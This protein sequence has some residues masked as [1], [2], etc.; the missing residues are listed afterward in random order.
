MI[1]DNRIEEKFAA[2]TLYSNRIREL[3]P[4]SF[5]DYS[6]SDMIKSATER[7]LQLISDAELD[8]LA[9]LYKKFGKETI[10]TESSLPAKLE[11]VLNKGILEKYKERRELRNKLVHAYADLALDKETFEQASDLKDIDDFKKAIEKAIN[12]K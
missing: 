12:S 11:G 5:I 9:S 8:V 3:L 4:K 6:K 10:G 7:N 1:G 2:L